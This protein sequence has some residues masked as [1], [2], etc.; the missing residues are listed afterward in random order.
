[1]RADARVN[2]DRLLEVAAEAFAREGTGASLKAIART[3]G[4]GIG[5]LYRRFPSREVL[6]EAVYRHELE[7]ICEVAGQTS[8]RDWMEAF[9]DFM[10][11][12]HGLGET[13]RAILTSEDDKQQTRDRLTG[14]IATLMADDGTVRP[15]VD[16]RDLLMALGG[17]TMIAAEERQ[18]ELATRLIDLLLR[19]V[20]SDRA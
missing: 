10:A 19:G 7:Q 14:A 2:H 8:L 3:A 6:V 11:A 20:S 15:G 9:V 13:L 4:V 17:I 16:P 1:M 18:R 5:T 12:K